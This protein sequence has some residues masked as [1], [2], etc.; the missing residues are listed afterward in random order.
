MKNYSLPPINQPVLELEG[1]GEVSIMTR[2]DSRFER[3]RQ[4][5][6]R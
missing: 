5:C 3:A 6:G 1:W 2:A 4:V